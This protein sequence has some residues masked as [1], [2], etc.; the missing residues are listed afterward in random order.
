MRQTDAQERAVDVCST[1]EVVARPCFHGCFFCSCALCALC[2][3]VCFFL[4]GRSRLDPAFSGSWRL[5][6]QVGAL[7]LFFSFLFRSLAVS[8]DHC[9]A[10]S[11]SLCVFFLLCLP[12]L[13]LSLPPLRA[14]MH[15]CACVLLECVRDRSN[16]RESNGCVRK[17]RRASE[18]E[19]RTHV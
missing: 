7:L 18:K 2:A 17:G 6:E 12:S 1:F 16:V 9:R 4:P 19:S 13:F 14:R 11:L 8:C 3:V 10:S 5:R 15:G